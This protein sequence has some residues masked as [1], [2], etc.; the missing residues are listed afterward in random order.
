[1]SL[2]A[3]FLSFGQAGGLSTDRTDVATNPLLQT[4]VGHRTRPPFVMGLPGRTIN[5]PVY[6]APSPS[7]YPQVSA[8]MVAGLRTPPGQPFQRT[9]QVSNYLSAKLTAQSL[10]GV[11]SPYPI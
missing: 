5:A 8:N 9:T 7:A 4:L 2:K 11:T 3:W 10:A 1:M 6:I